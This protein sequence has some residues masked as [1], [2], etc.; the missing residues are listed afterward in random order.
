[1]SRLSKVLYSPVVMDCLF[2]VGGVAGLIG[3][4]IE[5]GRGEPI[6][7]TQTYAAK[8]FAIVVTVLLSSVIAVVATRVDRKYADDFLLQTLARSSMLGMFGVLLALA[9]WQIVFSSRLGG[10]SSFA[11]I[12]VVVSLWSLGYLYTRLRGTIA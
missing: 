5:A 10:L 7:P 3:A 8:V 6:E 1:M 9:F 2:A 4:A 11:T 12:G